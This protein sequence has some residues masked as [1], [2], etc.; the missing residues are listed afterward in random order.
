MTLERVNDEN[1]IFLCDTATGVVF[2]GDRTLL[3]KDKLEEAFKP[4]VITADL[5]DLL[6]NKSA[7][8]H[9]THNNQEH[10]LYTENIEDLDTVL[11]CIHPQL[12]PCLET[13]ARGLRDFDKDS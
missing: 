9:F 10:R 4:S 5:P 1:Y 12:S 2:V 3:F 7:C 13:S 11:Q 6:V 8:V